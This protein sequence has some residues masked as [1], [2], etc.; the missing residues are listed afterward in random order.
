MLR[1]VMILK[2]KWDHVEDEM[3]RNGAGA[4]SPIRVEFLLA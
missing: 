2:R 3:G 4:L 1:K